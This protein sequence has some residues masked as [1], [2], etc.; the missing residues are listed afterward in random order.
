MRDPTSATFALLVAFIAFAAVLHAVWTT[1]RGVAARLAWT[2]LAASAA[3]LVVLADGLADARRRP[4]DGD[5]R[6]MGPRRA[7]GRAR[8]LGLALAGDVAVVFVAWVLF[9]SLGGTF[10]AS[11]YT[12]DP[13]PRFA[14]VAL[15]DAP[16]ADGKATVVA[17]DVRGRAGELRRRTA[18]SG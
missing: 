10:G 7:V 14:V 3:L 6:G 18:A 4:P 2:G 15:P 9:W 17:H 8:P 11:G 1:D 16:R 5:A 12:P 13:Q